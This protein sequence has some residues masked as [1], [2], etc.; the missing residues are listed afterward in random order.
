MSEILL[1][2]RI[3]YCVN[4]RSATSKTLNSLLSKKLIP[5]SSL[6]PG[7][8]LDQASLDEI[9]NQ[10]ENEQ[11]EPDAYNKTYFEI[12]VLKSLSD[13]EWVILDKPGDKLLA[14]PIRGYVYMRTALSPVQH[15]IEYTEPAINI[16]YTNISS[17]LMHRLSKAKNLSELPA[18]AAELIN[19]HRP[20]SLRRTRQ[21][22]AKVMRLVPDLDSNTFQTKDASFADS[23]EFGTTPP[24]HIEASG[25]Q[26]HETITVF[27][28]YFATFLLID[29]FLKDNLTDVS[30]SYDN[31][32]ELVFNGYCKNGQ[33]V[34]V[35]AY[36]LADTRGNGGWLVRGTA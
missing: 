20:A 28:H 32:A 16:P 22:A 25:A 27:E 4:R 1:Y 2:P 10:I 7:M 19:A 12:N 9:K 8:A 26:A 21:R 13:Y 34:I 33:Q 11:L 18:A 36:K 24:K 23:R 3:L 17:V 29:S 31:S 15:Y 35:R 14:A 30:E 5:A 6:L